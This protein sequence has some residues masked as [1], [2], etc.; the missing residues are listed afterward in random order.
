MILAYQDIICWVLS[1]FLIEFVHLCSPKE[2]PW[3]K[4]SAAVLQSCVVEILELSTFTSPDSEQLSEPVKH[5]KH[6]SA[7]N[8]KVKG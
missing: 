2:K 7:A 1:Y 8:N 5:A 4:G 6:T 3:L